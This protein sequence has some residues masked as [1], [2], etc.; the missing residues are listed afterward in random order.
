MIKFVNAKINLG[1]NIIGKREDGY[2]LLQTIFV[3]VG[4]YNGTPANPE[5]FC[6]I[7]ELTQVENPGEFN[8]VSAIS[9][10]SNCMNWIDNERGIRYI[11]TGK[12]P[13]CPPE[14]NLVVKAASL[15]VDYVCKNY[16]KSSITKEDNLTLRLHKVLPDGAGMGG[17]SADATFTLLLLNDMLREMGMHCLDDTRLEELAV[18]IGADCPVF[19]KNRVAYAEGIGERLAPMPEL[20]SLLK[21]KWLAIAKPDLH[22]STK[23]AFAGVAP[24][25]PGFELKN[26]LQLPISAWRESIKNDFEESLF[27]KYPVLENI[28]YSLYN[29]GALYA[30]MTGSGAALYGIFEEK[31]T[32]QKALDAISSDMAAYKAVVLC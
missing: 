1:L 29:S 26:I 21:G 4:L 30:S 27:P 23:E 32:A 24:A 8:G 2:H 15:F 19:V 28:K 17:G 14:K 7:L 18:K 31:D 25:V 3:P 10:E 11:F 20:A 22:I 12:L 6:D 16:P 9:H 13:D 5:P